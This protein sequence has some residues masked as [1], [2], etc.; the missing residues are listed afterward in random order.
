[1]SKLSRRSLVASAASL[2]ALA[3]PAVAGA[4]PGDVDTDLKQLGVR[5]L[6][7]HRMFDALHNDRNATDEDWE[8]H[9]DEQADLVPKILSHTAT[10]REGPAVQ[11]VACIS[12]CQEIWEEEGSNGA[13]DTERPFIEAIA[14][15]AG[16]QHPVRN[17]KPLSPSDE[18]PE[19]KTDPIYGAIADFRSAL[20]A[21]EK[22]FDADDADEESDTFTLVSAE[23]AKR[24]DALLDTVPR[25]AEGLAAVVAFVIGNEHLLLNFHEAGDPSEIARFLTTVARAAFAQAGLPAR[26]PAPAAV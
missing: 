19:P 9:L 23:L 24:R 12:G 3:A 14:R 8:P 25:S 17:I 1:M 4:L 2:P 13:L 16:V 5:L 21:Y 10:S 7:V 18:F 11:V 6:R 15:Y 22:L 26:I 20:D